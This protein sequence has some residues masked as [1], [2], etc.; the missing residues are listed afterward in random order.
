MCL[1]FLPKSNQFVCFSRGSERK[2][3]TFLP[4]LSSIDIS[5]IYIYIYTYRYK[6]NKWYYDMCKLVVSTVISQQKPSTSLSSFPTIPSYSIHTLRLQPLQWHRWGRSAESE[7]TRSHSKW[8]CKSLDVPH[9]TERNDTK[10]TPLQ[11][12]TIYFTS[13]FWHVV[14]FKP[15]QVLPYRFSPVFF[16]V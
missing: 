9:L 2:K 5:Y 6:S 16:Q 1:V 3:D 13:L 15:N 8:Y 14:I 12:T 7:L 10:A 4:D 11:L